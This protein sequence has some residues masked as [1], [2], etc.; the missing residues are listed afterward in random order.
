MEDKL[1]TLAIHT[2]EK[3][4]ILKTILETEGIE[5]YI[6][7]VNQIQPVVSAGVRVRIKE[8]DLPHALRIIEDSKWLSEDTEEESTAPQV[9]KILI[10]VDFSDYSIK[11]CEL[12][13]N[14]AYQAGAEVMIMH[15]YFS[16]YFPSAIPMGD[17]L[18]YQVNEEE[19]VQNVLKR[20]QIDMENICTMINRKIQAGELPKVKYNY[21]LREGLPEEEIIAYCKEYHPT[22]IV[23]GTRGKSQKDMDLIG[24]V[25]GEVIEVNK[26]PVL[27]IPENIRFND[28]SDAKNIAFATSFNQR[29]LVAF[30]EFMEI[31]KGYDVNIHLF[32][33]STSKDE[34]NEIR[35]TGVN[36]Y[37]K[38]QYPDANISHTVLADGDLLLAIEKFVRDKQIDVIALST[39]RRNILARMFNPSIARKML[40]HTDTPLLVM[41][42]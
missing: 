12:G 22:L 33:I 39:Y 13:I 6:H 2:F 21:V 18:A 7:N 16:P 1:V 24:S 20:V 4:Q 27:A 28:L 9:K 37:F 30:D 26:V 5:V 23:M 15:A 29:D 11:A 38:K 14:Y 36:E 10:P 41:H 42:S 32:N 40:F 25:T 31:I 17:T 34:W 19:S 3:A 8:S 35:L